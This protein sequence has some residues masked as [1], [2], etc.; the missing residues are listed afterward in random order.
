[1]RVRPDSSAARRGHALH[2]A[3][4]TAL[5]AAPVFAV[6][7]GAWLIWAV[8]APLA[9]GSLAALL[10]CGLY[11]GYNHYALVH[12][13]L[14]HHERLVARVGWGRIERCH[15]VHHA[16]HD[17]NFGVTTTLWD[18]IFGTYQPETRSRTSRS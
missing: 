18:R 4:D 5:I 12:H 13:V 17:V 8:L 1:M 15:R 16:C 10:V 2:H 6:M 14:H 11:A 3:D 9:G 7:A